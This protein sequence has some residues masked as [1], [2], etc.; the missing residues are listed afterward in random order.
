[1]ENLDEKPIEENPG[2]ATRKDLNVRLA[3][4]KEIYSRPEVRKN[5]TMGDVVRDAS[6]VFSA[7]YGRKSSIAKA[8]E[9]WERRCTRW[10]NG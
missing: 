8:D 4:L 6:D 7:V 9:E 5:L 10:E 2:T 1:M 3:S